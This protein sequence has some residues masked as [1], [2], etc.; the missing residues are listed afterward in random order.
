MAQ[1]EYLVDGA[2]MTTVADAIR[3]KGGTTAPLSFPEGMASA[4]R[5]I[6]S[7]GT[8]ISLGL[9]AATVGQTVKVKAVDTDGKPTA[10]EAVDTTSGGGAVDDVQIKGSSIV[11]V[12]GVAEIPELKTSPLR[13]PSYGLPT[14]ADGNTPVGIGL[15][16]NGSLMTIPAK[17]N[18][19][20]NRK[21]RDYFD[22]GS[23]GGD[24]HSSICP[25]YLDYSVKAAM[26]DG[27]GAAWTDVERLAAL[28]RMGC[29]VDDNGFVKWTAQEVTG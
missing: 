8:D 1:N 6:P 7:G 25:G 11:G 28:L 27:K 13:N 23:T 24:F 22:L 5:D 20:A 9:T 12:S 26:C 14:L 10:W 29:T 21:E 2:D 15:H 18:D 3:E 17:R 16:I 19:I 4:V